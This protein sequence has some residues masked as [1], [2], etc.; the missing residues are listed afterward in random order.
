MARTWGKAIQGLRAER[1]LTQKQV[2]DAI[3]VSRERV[4]QWEAE[5]RD[6]KTEYTVKLA[7]F[8]GVT[9]DEI[10]RGVK[11]NNVDCHMKTG[12]SNTAIGLLEDW[13]AKSEPIATE[14]GYTITGATSHAQSLLKFIN[15]L[16]C[17][18]E[19]DR[20]AE[21]AYFFCDYMSRGFYEAEIVVHL[22]EAASKDIAEGKEP[23]TKL[24]GRD[25]TKAV[26]GSN[27]MFEDAGKYEY[28][29]IKLLSAF[30]E[31]YA[32]HSERE[33]RALQRRL[34]ELQSITLG[35]S[36]AAEVKKE[37]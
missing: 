24:I 1:G 33:V 25:F 27:L 19:I 14:R 15:A 37:E 30:L 12:L 29:A 28:M 3:G 32:G 23:E 11:A 21:C 34:G 31:R 13:K 17:S 6:M 9:C 20:M 5:D 22:A 18:D 7:D 26:S 8:F 2:A 16:I 10:L 4:N 36:A 35:H